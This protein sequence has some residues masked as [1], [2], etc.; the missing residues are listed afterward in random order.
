MR[1]FFYV[2]QF[3]WSK[4][5]LLVQ[6]KWRYIHLEQSTFDL[7]SLENADLR[8]DDYSSDLLVKINRKRVIIC[9]LFAKY[10]IWISL[11]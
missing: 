7:S 4:T 1:Q 3:Y 6:R 2:P 8:H 9:N 11:H 10:G 5:Q